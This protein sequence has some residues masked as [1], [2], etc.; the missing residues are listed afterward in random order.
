MKA[1]YVARAWFLTLGQIN[2]TSTGFAQAVPSFYN[3]L[4]PYLPT[5]PLCS[6]ARKTVLLKMAAVINVTSDVCHKSNIH[7]ARLSFNVD[8]DEKFCHAAIK[9]LRIAPEADVCRMQTQNAILVCDKSGT[10][11]TRSVRK[12]RKYTRTRRH[13]CRLFIRYSESGNWNSFQVNEGVIASDWLIPTLF[14][15]SLRTLSGINFNYYLQLT[16]IDFRGTIP[17][18]NSKGLISAICH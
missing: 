17:A 10:P 4:L 14:W 8:V 7:R 18:S 6:I 16:L 11:F 9:H 2:T 3:V 15:N 5:A 13:L 12:S 1:G